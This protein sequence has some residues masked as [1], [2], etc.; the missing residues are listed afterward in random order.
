MIV[1][2]SYILIFSATFVLFAHM[3]N[4]QIDSV[5]ASTL[6]LEGEA[7]VAIVSFPL[8]V[9]DSVTYY[10]KFADTTHMYR[11]RRDLKNGLAQFAM[12]GNRAGDFAIPRRSNINPQMLYDGPYDAQ[13]LRYLLEQSRDEYEG[14]A[15]DDDR[16]LTDAEWNGV[17]ALFA[18]SNMLS[19]SVSFLINDADED[20][21]VSLEPLAI[22]FPVFK[23]PH[24]VAF[25]SYSLDFDTFVREYNR[26]HPMRPLPPTGEQWLERY[27]S[28]AVWFDEEKTTKAVNR[29][30]L[31]YLLRSPQYRRLLYRC[32]VNCEEL[33]SLEALRR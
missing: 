27:F 32:G 17:Y 19:I 20:G 23:S 3:A 14:P 6:E 4:A 18:D 31:A 12:Q 2:R 24:I 1:L 30:R 5:I 29:H 25:V 16:P 10:P 28:F 15:D 11:N 21:Q 7:R 22:H 8:Q 26:A 33:P 9:V 13:S